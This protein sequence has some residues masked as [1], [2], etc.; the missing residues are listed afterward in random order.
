MTATALAPRFAGVP[1]KSRAAAAAAPRKRLVVEPGAVL[2]FVE[3]VVGGRRPSSSSCLEWRSSSRRAERPLESGERLEPLPR[4]ELWRA[5]RPLGLRLRLLA[6][7]RLRRSS[8]LCDDAA[9]R[10]ES[11]T[12]LLRF[13]REDCDDEPWRLFPTGDCDL[14]RRTLPEVRSRYVPYT[15]SCGGCFPACPPMCS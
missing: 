14:P 2:R 13:S 9:L 12:L 1:E 3:V 7:S 10:S 8:S 15:F 6:R 5:E 4:F 11:K